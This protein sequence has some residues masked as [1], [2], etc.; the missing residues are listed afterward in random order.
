MNEMS[1]VWNYFI[2]FSTTITVSDDVISKSG[3]IVLSFRRG[4]VREYTIVDLYKYF[5]A[6]LMSI[7]FPVTIY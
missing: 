3:E 1:F 2:P 7:P 6:V 5:D 4:G